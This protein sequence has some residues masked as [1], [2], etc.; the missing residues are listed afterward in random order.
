M[1][2]NYYINK[3]DFYLPKNIEKNINV[4]KFAKRKKHEVNNIINKIGIK[5]RRI[6][7]KNEFTNDLAIKSALKLFKKLKKNEIDYVIL[8]TNTPDY[9]LPSNA[10]LI[11]SR[12]KL[13]K[14]IGAFDIILACSGYLYSLGVAKGLLATKQANKILLIT[15]DTYS[16]FIPYKD[17]KNRVLF[18]DGSTAS[19]IS[20]KKTKNSFRILSFANGT[21]GKGYKNAFIDNFGN[22]NLKSQNSKGDSLQLDGPGL[23]N[24]A[25][26][27]IPNEIFSYLSKN[28]LSLKKIDYFVFHQ[29]N[30]FMLEGLKNKLKIKSEKVIIDMTKTGNTTSSSI[31][32]ILSKYCKRI[33][34]GSKVLSV[35]FGG[36][37]S[38]AINL[39]IKQ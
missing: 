3:I 23:Y 7:N 16:K 30:K 2:Q 26:S 29:A 38:W 35:A 31:P 14:N 10:C 28:K 15:S 9:L 21:D 8:C 36:G 11:Q 4:L 6:A 39:L 1:P 27:Y 12:L 37:L 25:L 24:F 22:R 18:G 19:L 13:S 20:C 5:E 32:I 17:S 33:P 34:K